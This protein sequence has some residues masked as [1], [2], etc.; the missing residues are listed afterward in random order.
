MASMPVICLGLIILP[1]I[2]V[3]IAVFTD[4]QMNA[5]KD[6]TDSIG[7]DEATGGWVGW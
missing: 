6:E 2:I 7:I 1:I 5:N 3:L 4:G